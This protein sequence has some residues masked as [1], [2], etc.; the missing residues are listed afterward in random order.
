MRHPV[1]ILFIIMHFAVNGSNAQPAHAV[2]DE[3][4]GPDPLLHNGRFYSY[5]IPSTTTGTPYFNGP[6]FVKGS[7]ESKG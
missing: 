7:A 1:H 4:Y 5:Y 6:E 2:D 3:L